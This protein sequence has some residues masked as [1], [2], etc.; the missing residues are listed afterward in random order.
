MQF[1]IYLLTLVFLLS[2]GS[3]K[4]VAEPQTSSENTAAANTNEEE[5][6]SKDDK[7]MS[8]LGSEEDGKQAENAEENAA[9]APTEENVSYESIDGQTP[10]EKTEKPA[11]KKPE[12]KKEPSPPQKDKGE[13]VSGLKKKIESLEKNLAQKEK[14]VQNLSS[15]KSQLQTENS[16]LKA[17]TSSPQVIYQ[18]TGETL[19]AETYKIRYNEAYQLFLSKN[20]NAAIPM[21]EN[22]IANDANNSLA[23]NAQYWIGESLFGLRKFREAALAFEKVFTFKKSNKEED[24][25]FKVGYCYSLIKDS[26]NARLELNRFLSKYPSSRNAAR[27]RKI[28]ASL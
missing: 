22:L 27:A 10:E 15:E 3:S 7:L 9:V 19:D 14:Q 28:L 20:Y 6:S 23:D 26:E 18:N 2:C 13:D 21:F 24:A 4:Q 8:L 5:T 12:V 1:R 16:A 25:Q 17:A 11:E